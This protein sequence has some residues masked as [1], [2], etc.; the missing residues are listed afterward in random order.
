MHDSRERLFGKLAA[1]GIATTTVPYPSHQTVE[2]GKAQRG[3]MTGQ[4]TKNLLL[5][6]KKGTLFL[7]VA[8]EDRPIDLKTL[9]KRIGAQGRLGFAQPDQMREVLGCEPGSLTPLALI[10]D[11]GGTVRV[12][13]DAD[14]MRADQLNFHPLVNTESTA[15]SAHDLISFIESCGT[16]PM[17]VQLDDG[18]AVADS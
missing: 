1:L 17:L 6:D 12:V 9:H 13:L 18:Q 16:R 4:F 10:N 11:T 15:I 14:M 3:D 2:E 8:A 7:L 5:R